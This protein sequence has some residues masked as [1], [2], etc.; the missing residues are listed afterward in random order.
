LFPD[1]G[2][3]F[4]RS[5]NPVFARF[6]KPLLRLRFGPKTALARI[7]EKDWYGNE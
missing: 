4:P 2:I 1:F 7:M 5:E 3:R 6:L